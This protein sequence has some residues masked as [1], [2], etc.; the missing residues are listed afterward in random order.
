MLT[1]APQPNAPYDS[2]VYS[3]DSAPNSNRLEAVLS[4]VLGGPTIT[5]ASGLAAFHAML[6]FLN[7]KRIALRGGYHGCHGV[8]ALLSKLSGLQ[9]VDLDCDDAELGTGDVVHVETPV[10]PTG[11]ARD[12]A[13]YRAKADR[14]GAYLTVDA[15]FGP[16]PLQDPFLFGADVIMHSGTKYIG[17]HSDMLCGVLAGMYPDLQSFHLPPLQPVADLAVNPSRVADGWPVKL[18]EERLYLGG[19]LGSLEGWLGLRSMRTLELRVERQSAS[20][21]ALVAWL[22]SGLRHG[23]GDSSGSG[24][25]SSASSDLAVVARLV[26]SVSH[27]SLQAA[28]LDKLGSGTGDGSSSPSWLRKQMPRGFGPVFAMTMRTE[29]LARRLP[30]KLTL[31]HHATSLGGV[32]SLIEWRYMSDKN[33]DRRLLRISVGVEGVDDL[34]ADLVRGF[35]LLLAEEELQMG[36]G[37]AMQA[38]DRQEEKEAVVVQSNNGLPQSEPADAQVATTV[39]LNPP[40]PGESYFPFHE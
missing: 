1:E 33:C 26:E 15:T 25:S 17:G 20:A 14:C 37:V 29:N 6:V 40:G 34:R 9:A 4:S 2:H 38:R 19:V 30:S 16:P 3:R 36:K 23:S 27:A 11:E 35:R 24:S 28:E 18:R 32:E 5:Y 8:V 13:R 7:P 21:S 10:N 39:T 31:F 12:L 22:D